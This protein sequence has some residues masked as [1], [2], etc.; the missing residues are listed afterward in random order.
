MSSVVVLQPK[1][2]L[3]IGWVDNGVTTMMALLFTGKA[4]FFSAHSQN[5]SLFY[6]VVKEFIQLKN[7]ELP[8]YDAFQNKFCKCKPLEKE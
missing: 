8:P 6:E 5:S 4:H 2:F 1:H 7:Q 3:K